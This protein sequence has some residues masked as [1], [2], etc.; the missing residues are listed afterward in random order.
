MKAI[1]GF[2]RP[3]LKVATKPLT[4]PLSQELKRRFTPHYTPA[5]LFWACGYCYAAFTNDTCPGFVR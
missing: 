3:R 1:K 5:N 4:T 2:F